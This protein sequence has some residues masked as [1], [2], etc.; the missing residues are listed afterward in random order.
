MRSGGN[1]R[2][3][4]RSDAED[5][6][7]GHRPGRLKPCQRRLD[8][9]QAMVE[10]GGEQQ[11][12]EALG[13]RVVIADNARQPGQNR[14]VRINGRK[15]EQITSHLAH[16]PPHPPKIG[17]GTRGRPD[18]RIVQ[19]AP[20][21]RA[22]HLNTRRHVLRRQLVEEQGVAKAGIA[23]RQ[24]GNQLS[25]EPAEASIVPPTGRV[26]ADMERG[27]SA[28]HRQESITNALASRAG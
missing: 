19:R 17:D 28:R 15:E 9:P 6:G 27:R 20:G 5:L 23:G 3:R 16:Q 12:R 14:K 24:S 13:R 11:L 1:R 10:P 21:C 2:K 22:A 8:L 26:D 4:W 25:S 7:D 18:R